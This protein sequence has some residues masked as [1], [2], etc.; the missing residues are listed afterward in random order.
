MK[1]VKYQN[2]NKKMETQKMSLSIEEIKEFENALKTVKEY[3][4]KT[5]MVII[6]PK[7]FQ[8]VMNKIA[9]SRKQKEKIE[10]DERL[11]QV[12][13]NI[14]KLLN[15]DYIN[16]AVDAKIKKLIEKK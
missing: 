7:R 12:E 2:K 14:S 4:T 6:K 5:Q 13:N 11:T 1:K 9:D 16:Q 10:L 3:E 8:Q 15:S